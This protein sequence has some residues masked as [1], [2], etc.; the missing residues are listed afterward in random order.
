MDPHDSN[1]HPMTQ[2]I[3]TNA[4]PE[5]NNPFDNVDLVAELDTIKH[6]MVCLAIGCYVNIMMSFCILL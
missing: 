6:T 2:T 1:H 5:H 3:I 4:L